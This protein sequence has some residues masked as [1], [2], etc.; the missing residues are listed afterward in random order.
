LQRTNEKKRKGIKMEISTKRSMKRKSS[1]MAKWT[2]IAKRRRRTRRKRTWKG[3][4][5]VECY[6]NVMASHSKCF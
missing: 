4:Q 3:G 6:T 5:D 2:P 1:W